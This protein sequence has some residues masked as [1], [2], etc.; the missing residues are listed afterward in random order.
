M[1]L[2]TVDLKP[3]KDITVSAIVIYKIHTWEK[4]VHCKVCGTTTH[5][6]SPQ[7]PAG[8]R[9]GPCLQSSGPDRTTGA[10][11]ETA[12]WWSI[13]G[14]HVKFRHTMY[15]VLHYHKKKKKKGVVM[16]HSK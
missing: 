3:K 6:P 1:E 2:L 7:D 9:S 12:C 15:A 16:L 11:E 5:R 4:R 8:Y 13:H 10:A 14:C